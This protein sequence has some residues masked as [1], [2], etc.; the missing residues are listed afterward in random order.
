MNCAIAT[1]VSDVL[2]RLS[3]VH[4]N[5][6]QAK[7]KL[8]TIRD[9]FPTDFSFFGAPLLFTAAAQLTSR[10]NLINHL[11]SPI[12]VTISN[13]PG[14]RKPMYFAGSKV[15]A[16]LPVSIATHGCALNITLTSYMDRL[17]FGLIACK[18]AVPDVQV[19]A[20]HMMDEFQKLKDAVG[21]ANENKVQAISAG[22]A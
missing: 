17:D 14:S 9:V 19:I 22:N 11:P 21:Q 13:V 6:K 4:N 7:E 16:N 2:T 1:D 15:I 20:D 12:N 8:A 3:T 5:S 10:T 18:V